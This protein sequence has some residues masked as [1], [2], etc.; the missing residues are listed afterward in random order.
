MIGNVAYEENI[1]VDIKKRNPTHRNT[2]TQ[3][4][5]FILYLFMCSFLTHHARLCSHCSAPQT[6]GFVELT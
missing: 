5:N 3:Y 6:L 1:S 4:L 2:G